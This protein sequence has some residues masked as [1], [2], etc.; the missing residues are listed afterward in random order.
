VS[1]YVLLLLKCTAQ[2]G[3][4]ADFIH[5]FMDGHPY[6]F[7]FFISGMELQLPLSYTAA[8][9]PVQLISALS[10]FCIILLLDVWL[11]HC[12]ASMKP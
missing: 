1:G 2:E 10:G 6:M 11:K 4:I 5:F 7:L 12:F 3:L 9:L 8:F